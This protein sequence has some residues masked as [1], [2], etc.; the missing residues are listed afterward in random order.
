[1]LGFVALIFIV[2][3]GVK[4]SF[5]LKKHKQVF[6]AHEISS[7]KYNF[8]L[9]SPAFYIL[10]LLGLVLPFSLFDLFRPIPIGFLLLLPGI[11][12][13]NQVSGALETVGIDTAVNASKAANN[14]MWLGIGTAIFMAANITLGLIM[15]SVGSDIP[16]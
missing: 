2:Y 8:L 14:I 7:S 5:E 11:I 9:F 12:L 1:M 16:V 10:S 3:L 15:D 13:G 4:L 6:L